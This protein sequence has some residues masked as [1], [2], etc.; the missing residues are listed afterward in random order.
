MQLREAPEP[1]PEPGP[2][3]AGLLDAWDR[4]RA[5]HDW[6]RADEMRAHLE[7][8]GVNFKLLVMERRR[9]AADGGA[10]C[11]P[12]WLKSKHWSAGGRG[13]RWV[14]PCAD[15]AQ[16]LNWAHSPQLRRYEEVPKQRRREVGK[17]LGQRLA[18]CCLAAQGSGAAPPQ[19][20]VLYVEKTFV[21]GFVDGFGAAVASHAPPSA[22]PPYVLLA[23][24][25]G[26]QPLTVELCELLA[27][28]PGLA[29]C[30]ANN[31]HR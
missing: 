4:A 8:T 31:L 12:P 2:E 18:G 14:G 29:A 27:T 11:W 15:L 10:G 23:I 1:E 17:E 22:V 6:P 3:L 9:H 21:R 20:L 26:D 16:T 7:T 19:P 5:E 30:Y 25:G 24:N 13:L 28:L